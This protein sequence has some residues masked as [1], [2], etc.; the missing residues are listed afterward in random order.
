MP[1]PFPFNWREPDYRA[2]YEWRT[3]RLK[4][5]RALEDTER[6]RTIAALKLFYSTNP[7]QFIIDWGV[8]VDPRRADL[9]L[10]T[11]VPFLLFEKQ[12]EWVHW[13]M[14]RW[15]SREPG[16]T[17]KARDMGMSW[18]TVGVA[19]TLC[20]F[21]R[22]LTAGF[23][24]RKEILVDRIGDPDSLFW[25]AREYVAHVPQEFRAGWTRGPEHAPAMRMIFP[26]TG[27]MMRG[28]AGDNIGRGGRASF[29]FVDEAAHLE[30]PEAVDA[31]LSQNTNCRM[32]LSSVKGM[33]NSFAEKR[34]SGRVKVFVFDWR[35]DPRKG[36]EWYEKQK[37][38]LD[39]VVLA[40]EVDRD[41]S[42]AVSGVVIP[43]AWVQAAVDAHK[44]LKIEPTGQ[45]MGGLDIADEGKDMNAFCGGR[46]ILIE[47]VKEWS[48]VGSDLFKTTSIAFDLCDELEIGS[49]KYDA[50][51]LGAG[52]RGDARI[53]NERRKAAGR[54]VLQVTPYRGSGEIF[55]PTGEDEPGRPNEDHFL[56]AKA[57]NWWALRRRFMKTYRAVVE[58][59]P[60]N[61]DELISISSSC[62]N[63][64]KLMTELSQ[65][66]WD[67]NATGK[68]FIV[69]AP[70]GSKSPNLADSVVIRFAR[71]MRPAMKVS[72][73][74]LARA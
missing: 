55:D 35:D 67:E 14:D 73:E 38:E 4:R 19:A 63:Y 20:M 3:E 60:F 25:K 28:E 54:K 71:T 68:K 15:Q 43:S 17:E 9:G 31:A 2:V 22:G 11:V 33:A 66:V 64:A 27:S 34:F 70:D 62:G 44:K 36:P 29:Y 1:I 50:D 53:I 46:G 18:L 13:F 7:A 30:H 40:Q 42:A 39:P 59:A 57:Q 56:N 16:L 24:S 37:R 49:F 32:D 69:K 61:P 47:L 21:R 45:R 41:Y 48:G 6:M 10:A 26:H 51:G 8:T 65:A 52:V 72:R 12:E 23:G 58:G 5:L 74:A